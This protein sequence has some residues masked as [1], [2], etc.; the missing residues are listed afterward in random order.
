MVIASLVIYTCVVSLRIAVAG[1][2]LSTPKPGGTIEG[3]RHAK[4][5]GIRAMEMEWVQQ[6]PSNVKHMEEIRAVSEELNISLTVHAPYYINLNSPEEAKL[7]ASKHRILKALSM[8]EIAGVKSVCVHAAFYLGLPP[9]QAYDNIAKAVDEILAEKDKSFPHVNLALET[10]GKPS[11]FGT[12][13]ECLKISKQFDIYPCIDPAHM[14]ARSNGAVNTT[15]E[16]NEML[17]LY[18]EALGKDSLKEMHMH[19]SGI[20]YG[21]KGEKHHVPLEESDAR[22]RDFLAVLKNRNVGGNLVCESP[23]LEKDTILMMETFAAL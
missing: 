7:E 20:A 11:Q 17:D 12:L 6:V 1:C 19:F 10:M 3:L 5:M 9:E 16:W 23:L 22:W 13:E 8:G 14:H 4:T 18:A 21:E 2:P 15:E